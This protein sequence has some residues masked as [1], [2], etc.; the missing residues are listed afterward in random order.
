MK[1][2]EINKQ[3]KPKQEIEMRI[4]MKLKK[5]S[6]DLVDFSFARWS[7]PISFFTLVDFLVKSEVN[8]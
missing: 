1:K 7:H 3:L 6:F 5:N 8:S 4:K 2:R